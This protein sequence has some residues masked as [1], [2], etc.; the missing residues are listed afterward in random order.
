MQR[1]IKSRRRE[2]DLDAVARRYGLSGAELRLVETL[3]ETG[4]LRTSATRLHRSHNTLRAQL[5]S[6]MQKTGTR[7][8]VELMTCIHE[9]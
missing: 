3:I 4:S 8:Q 9:P 1:E 7:S 6:I 5:R 2:P